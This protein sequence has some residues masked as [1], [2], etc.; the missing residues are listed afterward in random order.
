[1][2]KNTYKYILIAACSLASV[3][4]CARFEEQDVPQ[5]EQ[6]VRMTFTAQIEGDA[7]TKT[8]LGGQMGDEYRKVLWQP[9]DSVGVVNSLWYNYMDKFVNIEDENSETATFEGTTNDGS[10]FY[11]FYPYSSSLYAREDDKI[12]FTLSASQTYAKETFTSNAMPMVAKGSPQQTL[13]FYSLCGVLGLNLKG[14]E[15]I[16]SISFTGKDANGDPLPVAGD[17]YVYMGYEDAPEIYTRNSNNT[18]T[19]TLN[20]GEGVALDPVDST[21]FYIVL[22]PATYE[23]F[24]III[25]TTD[26]KVMLKESSK[27]LTIKR[28]N[29]TKT[30]ALTYVANETIDLSTLGTANSYIVSE[31]GLYSI[32]A[33]VIGNGEFGIIEGEQFHTSRTTIAPSSA[34]LLWEDRPGV[35]GGVTFSDGKINFLSTG[36]KGNALV[37]A[38]GSDGEIL[39]S[40]HIWSTDQPA[41]QNYVNSTGTYVMLDRNIGAIRADRGTTDDHWRESIGLNYQWGRK[42][43]FA[44]HR[45]T[46]VDSQLYLHETIE[47]PTFF[48]AGND[49]WTKEWSRN[50]WCLGQKTI[51]DPCPVGYR[52]AVP[53]VWTGFT[54][55]GESVDRTEN[56]NIAGAFDYGWSFYINEDAETAWYPV[57][58]EV[59]YWA[60][61]GYH[62]TGGHIWSAYNDGGNWS[63]SLYFY[64]NSDLECGLYPNNTGNNPVY[65][66]PV[67]CMKDEIVDGVSVRMHSVEDIT[68]NSA[69]ASAT[70]AVRGNVEVTR[71][72]LVYGADASVTLETGTVVEYEDILGDFTLTLESLASYT[73]YYVKAFAVTTDGS[74]YYSSNTEVFITPTEDGKLNLSA[75]GTA[76]S[77]ML[78]P[79][80]MEYS[81]NATVIGNGEFGLVEGAGFHTASTAIAPTSVELLWEDREGLIVEGKLDFDGKN[82]TFNTSGIEGNALIAAKDDNGKTIWSWHIWVTDVP[83]DHIYSNDLGTFVVQDRNL[84]ATRADRG[85]GEQWKE[86][87]GLDFQWGRKDPFAGKHL[88]ETNQYYWIADFIL[89]P[90]VW[91]NDWER[92]ESMWK[93]DMKTIYDPCPVGYRVA[94]NDVWNGFST[95]NTSGSFDNGWYFRYDGVKTAWYP[96]RYRAYSDR[97]EYWGDGYLLSSN[98][99]NGF[100]YDRWSAYTQHMTS[101]N[102]RCMKDENSTSVTVRIQSVTDVTA[103]TAS[104]SASVASQGDIAVERA[105]VV[106]GTSSSVSLENGIVMDAEVTS[107]KFALTLEKLE[108]LKKYYVKAFAVATDGNT[109]Y[110]DKTLSFITPGEDGISDLSVGGT[111]NS[112]IV[113]PVKGTYVF[114]LVKGN[115]NESVGEVSSV[116]VLWET[117]NNLT[118]VVQG[119]IV[120]SASFENGKA[121][122]EIPEGAVSGNALLAAKDADGNVLWSWHI[123]VADYD[124][125]MTQ[126]TYASGAIMMDRNLGAISVE[127]GTVESFGFFYQW[128]RKDP[129]VIPGYMTTYPAE[130]ITYEYYDSSNDTIENAVLHPT[131]VYDDARWN[132]RNDLW[133]TGKTKTIYDPCPVG[134]KVSDRY[135]WEGLRRADN[136]QTGYYQ[137][138]PSSAAPTAYIPLPGYTEGT[139]DLYDPESRGH[140]WL[141]EGSTVYFWAWNNSPN[142]NFSLTR[143]SLMGV[144]CMKID[145]TGKPGGGDD[146]VVDDEYEWE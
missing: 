124:P 79:I 49:R 142:N 146:Y 126:Q 30:G 63:K 3:V 41:D 123:W 145:D 138:S 44:E 89:H 11:M 127:P 77:Y 55:T 23:S 73:K 120:E 9:E 83:E 117:Y 84:G 68:V 51:Y 56:M 85:L 81:F 53:D 97:I 48:A 90:D 131:T 31:S 110:S 80:A 113:Y 32:D 107:G 75:D 137:L 43:P 111:A 16:Q 28:T 46:R 15:T 13:Q 109:Y 135:A 88:L 22:P 93:T 121:K 8:V 14:S 72:G 40:W 140:V 61:F 129:F 143:D 58:S 18:A 5:V 25:A 115:S 134:W 98:H 24:N 29:V 59:G 136:S 19:V 37:A 78:P 105:G 47:N 103:T 10:T 86:S 39:W 128:G 96:N 133:A 104:A 1:M 112:Y 87:T 76:N 36:E 50:L 114:D 66:Y 130:A 7:D 6:K 54:T 141:T 26:G 21:A 70:V 74:T 60:D 108:S 64:Y 4:S 57:T 71:S 99:Q 35:I 144:R 118:D 52:V 122:F 101:G 106:Y 139:Q 92:T 132:D 12:D 67:R 116:E 34:K 27:P 38:T 42:D 125:E 91:A 95:E 119:T 102:V 100:Y 82:V 94:S 2:M 65:A 45:Y 17:Y 20:C 62:G 69:K 33:T